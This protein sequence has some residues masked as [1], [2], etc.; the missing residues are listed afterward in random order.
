M[1]G[2]DYTPESEGMITRAFTHIFGLVNEL[3]FQGW[4]YTIE[5]QFIEIYND[6]IYNLLISRGE[7]KDV[8]ITHD[9]NKDC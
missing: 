4:N 2:S 5:G 8:K 9:F 7:S 6:Q 1:Q 3:E